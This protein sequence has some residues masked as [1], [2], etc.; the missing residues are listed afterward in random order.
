MRLFVVL[1]ALLV[2]QK[3]AGTAG[4]F[5]N[6]REKSLM[7]PKVKKLAALE[8]STPL[9]IHQLGSVWAPN[10]QDSPLDCLPS[11]ETSLHLP[12]C[13]HWHQPMYKGGLLYLWFAA[14]DVVETYLDQNN[15]VVQYRQGSQ[16]KHL[17]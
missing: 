2:S 1:N 15:N 7:I 16:T 5:S 3:N 9:F 4:L 13:A 10:V 8:A 14:R 12:V 17:C 6:G 11:P